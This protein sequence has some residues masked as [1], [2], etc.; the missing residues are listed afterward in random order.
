[1][2]SLL[3][4]LIVATSCFA[5]NAAD[6]SDKRSPLDRYRNGVNFSILMSQLTLKNALLRDEIGSAQDENT[7][8]ASRIKKGKEEGKINFNKALSTVKKP[9]AREALKSYQVAFI[10]AL[11]GIRPGLDERKISYEVRQQALETKLSEAWAR[12]EVEQ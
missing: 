11:E 7:D 1:M 2:K 10:S 5:A 3:M 9:A 12:F 6:V 4:F 8:Y